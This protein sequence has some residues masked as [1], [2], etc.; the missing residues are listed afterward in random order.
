MLLFLLFISN[1]NNRLE[2]T[3]K[4]CRKVPVINK[5]EGEKKLDENL[6]KKS[7]VT[8]NLKSIN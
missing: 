3:I 4:E 6:L 7:Q 2:N 8:E 1:V 5:I